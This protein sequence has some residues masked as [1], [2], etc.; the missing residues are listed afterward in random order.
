[1]AGG[2]TL[3][4]CKRNNKF[5]E[6]K[7]HSD[8]TYTPNWLDR[9]HLGFFN[10]VLYALLP[11]SKQDR[12]ELELCRPLHA[13]E[14]NPHWPRPWLYLRAL[15][16]FIIALALLYTC[17]TI[18][19]R[20]E[21]SNLLPGLAIVGS[22]IVPITL[23]IFFWEIN[24]WRSLTLLDILKYFLVGSSLS[25]AIT[26]VLHYFLDFMPDKK[27]FYDNRHYF[28]PR[29]MMDYG[30][31]PL[32]ITALVEESAKAFTILVILLSKR[33]KYHILHG[34]LVGAA[35]GAGF[36]VFESAG[37]IIMYQKSLLAIIIERSL[38]ASSCHVA[39][40]ALMGGAIAKAFD[41]KSY[42]RLMVH[43]VVYAAFFLVCSLHFVW[44]YLIDTTSRLNRSIE[45]GVVTW[46][47]L[48]LMIWLGLREIARERE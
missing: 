2:S 25:I 38:T 1:M 34:I 27:F 15:A 30:P 24:K 17:W 7:Q 37:Y 48:L 29:L 5:E 6:M 3:F 36:A 18:E 44:N 13:G 33:K 12:R 46:F 10:L 40:G 31:I 14:I 32:V 4:H 23:M 39:W 43:P 20:Y 47:M 16:L 35:V 41:G 42:L 26:F 11:H 22:L 9:H 28:T 19:Q 21:S 8:N 45:L